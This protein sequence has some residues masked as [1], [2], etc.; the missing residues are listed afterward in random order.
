[1]KFAAVDG[2]RKKS[3]TFTLNVPSGSNLEDKPHHHIA[4]KY[5]ERWGLVR[6]L[7]ADTEEAA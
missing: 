5:I 7:L 6:T 3:V 1:M 2:G 4:R